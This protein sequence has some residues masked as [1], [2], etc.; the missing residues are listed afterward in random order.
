MARRKAKTDKVEGRYQQCQKARTT[1]SDARQKAKTDKMEGRCQTRLLA[2]TTTSDARLSYTCPTDQGPCS[3][4]EQLRIPA[5]RTLALPVLGTSLPCLAC[6]RRVDA[7]IAALPRL[8]KHERRALLL[9]PAPS[10]GWR[11][12][13]PPGPGRSADE[14]HRRALRRL[15]AAGLLD[16]SYELTQGEH[17]RISWNGQFE[18][19]QRWSSTRG[20]ACL[21]PLGFAV[22]TRLRHALESGLPIRWDQHREALRACVSDLPSLLRMLLGTVEYRA[23]QA[24]R[25][26][27]LIP[28]IETAR[29]WAGARDITTAARLA[30]NLPPEGGSNP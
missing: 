12:I 13:P 15:V 1:T 9:A 30:L 29:A 10:A 23:A 3:V 14:A 25:N 24:R 22:V 2:D 11:H 19:S 7:D 16:L 4:V 21:S 26:M 17:R 8:G 18:W 5:D 28:T 20:T 27:S 6:P